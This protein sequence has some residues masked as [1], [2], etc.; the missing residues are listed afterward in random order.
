MAALVAAGIVRRVLLQQVFRQM[1]DLAAKVIAFFVD[2]YHRSGLV[3]QLI[4][5]GKIVVAFGRKVVDGFVDWFDNRQMC[6]P[7]ASLNQRCGGG[8][9]AFLV[10]KIDQCGNVTE[11]TARMRRQNHSRSGA[12]FVC[13]CVL[14]FCWRSTVL[15]SVSKKHF[16]LF[17]VDWN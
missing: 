9:F 4:H 5:K 12:L 8:D 11:S 6:G 13:C 1:G 17:G 15:A 2:G 7:G 16:L 10:G 14:P 3:F